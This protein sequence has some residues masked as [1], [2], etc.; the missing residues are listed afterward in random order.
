M[1]R[2]LMIT[3]VV[4]WICVFALK[5]T[6]DEIQK[7]IIGGIIKT[8]IRAADGNLDS[9]ATQSVSLVR[10][11]TEV[12]VFCAAVTNGQ[13]VAGVTDLLLDLGAGIELYGF[14]YSEIECAGVVSE[15]SDDYYRVVFAAPGKPILVKM[16]N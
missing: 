7:P 10:V 9:M 15:Q 5:A 1:T 14:A 2:L 16:S 3:M 13:E 6:S 12:R 8:T 11:D 4:P